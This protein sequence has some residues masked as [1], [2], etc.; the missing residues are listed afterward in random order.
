MKQFKDIFKD[1]LFWVIVIIVSIVKMLSFL[2]M[3]VEDHTPGYFFGAYLGILVGSFVFCL[4]LYS[5]YYFIRKGWPK[6]KKE[7]NT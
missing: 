5:I 6:S 7:K 2:Q 3:L 1:W 4:L